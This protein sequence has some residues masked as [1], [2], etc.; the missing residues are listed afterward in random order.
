MRSRGAI[1]QKVPRAPICVL[2]A[3]LAGYFQRPPEELTPEKLRENTA[4]LFRDNGL[5]SSR[6]KSESEA[7]PREPILVSSGGLL[8]RNRF[9]P[10]NLRAVGKRT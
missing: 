6:P 10:V 5:S 2:L 7:F 3:D 8:P 1:T 9:H 4:H